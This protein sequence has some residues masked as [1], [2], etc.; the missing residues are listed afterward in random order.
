MEDKKKRS[1]RFKEWLVRNEDVVAAGAYVV[2]FVGGFVGTIALVQYAQKKQ[3]AKLQEAWTRGDTI[4]PNGQGWFL[5][6][7]NNKEE[8]A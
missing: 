4:I 5:V 8:A 6:L 2:G 3:Q 1:E 7:E